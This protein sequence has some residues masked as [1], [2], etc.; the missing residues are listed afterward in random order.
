MEDFEIGSIVKGEVTGIEPYGIFVKVG[1]YDGLIHISEIAN[2]YI[3][4]ITKYVSIGEKIFMK[5]IE[6]DRDNN[7]LGLSIKGLNYKEF[8]K[9]RKVKESIRGF[10][11]LQENLERWMEETFKHGFS[12]G[13]TGD[14]LKG[15]KLIVSLTTGAPEEVYDNIDN[16][17]NPIKATCKLCNMEY[18]G[19]KVT[20]GVS[21]QIR[22]DK[23][24][25]IED[26]AINHADRLIEMIK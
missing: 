26:K 6:I 10:S 20:Y 21:Y 2:N 14:K 7:R 9:D 1:E 19:K 23:G 11:P 8:Y 4:N 13:T 3:S 15:K 24:K 5:V 12:H 18:V 25:E 16:Y 17:L 22:N